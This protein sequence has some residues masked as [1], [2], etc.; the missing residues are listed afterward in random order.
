MAKKKDDG[1]GEIVAEGEAKQGRG[2]KVFLP[3]GEARVDYIRRRYFADGAK[4]GDIAREL[5]G[6]TGQTVPY[7]IVFAATKQKPAEPAETAEA[8]EVAEGVTEAA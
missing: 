1:T 6:L 5:S 4:R 3:D 2:R 7:Q 8:T